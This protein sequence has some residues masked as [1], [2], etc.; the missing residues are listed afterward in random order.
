MCSVGVQS[1]IYCVEELILFSLQVP[2]TMFSLNSICVNLAYL[3]TPV[4]SP[5]LQEKTEI[6][7]NAVKNINDWQKT[8]DGWQLFTGFCT[9]QSFIMRLS[10]VQ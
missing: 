5:P 2:T 6:G 9:V 3:H 10:K 4:L 1:N 8:Y 7:Q